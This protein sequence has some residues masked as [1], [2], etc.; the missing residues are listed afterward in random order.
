M[1]DAITIQVKGNDA[2]LVEYV[3][4]DPTTAMRVANRLASLFTEESAQS[5]TEQVEDAYDFIRKQL[6]EARGQLEANEEAVRIYKERHLGT[7][8]EQLGANLSTLQR[9]QLEQQSLNDTIRAAEGRIDLMQK[10]EADQ[11]RA[12]EAGT[13]DPGAELEQL[14]SKLADLRSRYSELHP[15]VRAL[16]KKIAELQRAQANTAATEPHREA[17]QPGDTPALQQARL[18]LGNLVAKRNEVDQKIA[19][20]QARVEQTPRT[21]QELALLTRDSTVLRENYLGLLN[22]RFDAER[23]EKLERRWKGETFKTLDPAHFPEKPFSPNRLLYL[24]AGFLF[25]LVTGVGLA[26]AADFMDQSLRNVEE[27]E[28]TLSYPVLAIVTHVSE[29][30]DRLLIPGPAAEGQV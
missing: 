24:V 23:A 12:A 16:V 26:F 5:R 8:P 2:F 9:L 7:L 3:N 15:D 27:L 29:K 22:K 6:D 18:D 21:E 4:R 19:A 10:T 14:R 1:R 25:G 17:A 28:A 13:A 11:A 30:K 20:F